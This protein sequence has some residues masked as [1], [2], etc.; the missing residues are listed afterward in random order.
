MSFDTVFFTVIVTKTNF[1]AGI[2]S[3]L[4][5]TS[6]MIW[7]VVNGRTIFKEQMQFVIFLHLQY[8]GNWDFG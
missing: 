6:N 7:N 1:P 3:K 8:R 4:P 2:H 5:G